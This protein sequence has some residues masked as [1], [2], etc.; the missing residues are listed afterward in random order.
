MKDFTRGNKPL[1]GWRCQQQ[2]FVYDLL[3]SKHRRVVCAMK[4][5]AWTRLLVVHLFSGGL[6]IRVSLDSDSVVGGYWIHDCCGYIYHVTMATCLSHIHF[7]A[8]ISE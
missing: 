3:Q 8:I 2:Q 5:W 6:L 4:H 1:I 7:G